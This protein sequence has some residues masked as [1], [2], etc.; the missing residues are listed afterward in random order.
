MIIRSLNFFLYE[1]DSTGDRIDV[2]KRS[3]K[4]QIK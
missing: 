2:F 3:E 1:L 4:W